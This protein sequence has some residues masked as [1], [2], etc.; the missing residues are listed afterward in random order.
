MMDVIYVAD[1]VRRLVDEKRKSSLV[2]SDVTMSEVS[3]VVHKE[4]KTTLNSL[5]KSG[6]LV[7]KRQLNDISFNLKENGNGKV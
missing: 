5:V 4:L 3:S 2:P 6:V 1:V 7:F